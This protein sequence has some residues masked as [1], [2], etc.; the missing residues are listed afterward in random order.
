MRVAVL[1]TGIMGFPIARNIA[2]AEIEV[3][4]WN[5]TRERAE[6]LREHG[7]E[8]SDR[9][10]DA[11]SGADLVITILSDGEAVASVMSDGNALDACGD[12]T[13]WA[14]MST[15]GLKATE[16]FI[17]LAGEAAVRFVDAPVTGSKE[18]AEKGQLTVLAS[19]PEDTHGTC[20]PVFDAIGGKTIWMPNAGDGQRFKMIANSWVVGLTEA[21]AETMALAEGLGV[22]SQLFLE[23]IEGGPLDSAYAQ[24]KGR[25]MIEGDFPPSFPLVHAA[26]DARLILEAAEET[27][28]H[29][30]LL[31]AVR[32]QMAHGVELGHGDEDMAATYRAAVDSD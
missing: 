28:L 29:L 30:P 14:Q 7:V 23:L 25:M 24:T 1:G 18:P 27:E 5:R 16:R 9:P 8:V 17:G 26:K 11:V 4:A 10:A 22:E 2:G 31:R 3:S 13:V 20:D 19:G 12:E 32:D 21:V 15:I 6:P